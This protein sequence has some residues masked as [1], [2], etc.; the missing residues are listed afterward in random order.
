VYVKYRFTKEMG[1]AVKAGFEK[2]MR[3]RIKE[4]ETQALQCGN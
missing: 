4:Y 3:D 2:Q 1:K